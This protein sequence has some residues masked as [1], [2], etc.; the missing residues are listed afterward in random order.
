MAFNPRKQSVQDLAFIV[1]LS[2]FFLFFRLGYGSLASW[3]EGIYASVSKELLHSSNWLRL[4]FAGEDW[5]DKPPL[6][7]WLTAL[8]Y[9]LF[10][11][12]EFS[13]RFVSAAFGFG[14]VIVTYFFAKRLINRWTGFLAS[15]VLLSSSH[16]LHFARFGMLDSALTF[17]LLLA[18]YFFWLGHERNRY[19][20]FS[21]IAIGLA[22]LTKGFAALYVF[23]VVWIYCWWSDELEIV[24]RSSYWIGVM[25]AVA[26]ALPWNLYETAIH[27]QAVMD[28]LVKEHLLSRI[29]VPMDINFQ[30]LYY[31]IRTFVNKFHPWVL[32]GIISAPFFL[33]KAI[34]DREIET[35]FVSVWIFF[36]VAMITINPVKRDWYILPVYPAVSITVAY[37][38]TRVF[39]ESH[40]NFIRALF[41][42]IMILHVPY[43]HIFDHDYSREIK[44]MKGAIEKEVPLGAKIYFY[45]YHESPALLFYTNRKSAD[46][47]NEEALTLVL[48]NQKEFYCIAKKNEWDKISSSYLKRHLKVRAT[49]QGILLLTK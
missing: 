20:I 24:G 37:V 46:L 32:V 43:S 5:Y 27:P 8:A 41:V 1:P 7:I 11:V 10:G 4:T 9:K 18:L 17:F 13:A 16:F 21:G 34:R 44:A 14:T 40:A 26:I 19:L 45:N 3:D 49:S 47:D 38:M 2:L 29:F 28:S 39:N 33:Y 6:I 35:Q 30:N 31:Y 42:V 15:L 48:K 36:I 23:P 22:T 12:S 25:L